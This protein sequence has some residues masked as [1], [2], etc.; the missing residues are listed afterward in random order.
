MKKA[1]RSNQRDAL[2]MI[3]SFNYGQYHLYFLI[4]I[5]IHT[6]PQ[7]STG[8]LYSQHA[9]T[10]S[11]RI[12]TRLY[13]LQRA[14]HMVLELVQVCCIGSRPIHMLPKLEQAC[15]NKKRDSYMSPLQ[16]IILLVRGLAN[17]P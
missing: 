14:I 11:F 6:V 9:H 15:T 8:L 2:I 1:S 5:L 12:S 3:Y 10:Y 16:F 7:I 13:Y 4:S 17:I